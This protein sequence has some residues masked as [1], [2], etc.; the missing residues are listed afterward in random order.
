[1][2]NSLE[3]SI[4]TYGAIFKMVLFEEIYKRREG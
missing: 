1:M 3:K 2:I 4:E